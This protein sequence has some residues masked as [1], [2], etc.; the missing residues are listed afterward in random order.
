MWVYRRSTR[1]RPGRLCFGSQLFVNKVYRLDLCCN[2]FH[3]CCCIPEWQIV[4]TKSRHEIVLKHL[5][6]ALDTLH[7]IVPLDCQFDASMPGQRQSYGAAYLADHITKIITSRWKSGQNVT[8]RVTVCIVLLCSIVF[9][10]IFLTIFACYLRFWVL[11]IPL[12]F[13]IMCI[14]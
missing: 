4:R 2:K 13:S 9:N 14:M 10:H 12:F 5:E 8:R 11:L 1:G 7:G 3:F 6:T